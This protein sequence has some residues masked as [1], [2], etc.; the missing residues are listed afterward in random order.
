VKSSAWFE[1]MPV[2]SVEVTEVVMPAIE[3]AIKVWRPI[4]RERRVEASAK[5]AVEDPI[6]WDERVRVKTRIASPTIGRNHPR[7]ASYRSPTV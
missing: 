6:A 5:W 2:G 4:D 1:A 3:S 7:T